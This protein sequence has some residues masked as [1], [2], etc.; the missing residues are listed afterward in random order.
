M[1][2]TLF[3][4]WQTRL[5]LFATVGVLV[6]LPFALGYIGPGA[7]AQFFWV[8]LYAALFGLGWDALYTYLQK[9]RWDRDWPGALQLL[10]GLWEAVFIVLLLKTVGLF[11]IDRNLSMSGFLWHYSSIW[12]AIYLAAHSLMRILFPRS[13]FRGGQ[14]L[15]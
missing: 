2:P 14:W 1:T 9:L 12:L 11:G 7:S 8:L 3:G 13:R 5:F 4:R 10:A 15:F 6:T